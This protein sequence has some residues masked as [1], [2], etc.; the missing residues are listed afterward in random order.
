MQRRRSVDWFCSCST[1]A[2]AS[3]PVRGGRGSGSCRKLLAT[4]SITSPSN[5]F[6]SERYILYPE[7]LNLRFVRSLVSQIAAM[8]MEFVWRKTSNSAFLME[9]EFAFHANIRRFRFTVKGKQFITVSMI[10]TSWRLDCL[11]LGVGTLMISTG[12]IACVCQTL[13]MDFME[14]IIYPVDGW[15]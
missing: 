9:T 15:F 12:Y 13:R 2:V 7:I 4:I 1:I 10:I 8:C 3:R 14:S 6:M 5:W 11:Y